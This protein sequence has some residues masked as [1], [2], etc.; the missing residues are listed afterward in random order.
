MLATVGYKDGQSTISALEERELFR[1]ACQ[2]QHLANIC[3][4]QVF[5]PV[6]PSWTMLHFPLCFPLLPTLS[7]PCQSVSQPLAA[8]HLLYQPDLLIGTKVFLTNGH[9]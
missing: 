2:G 1:V 8:L 9:M 3:P 4:P 7:T 5:I 6:H